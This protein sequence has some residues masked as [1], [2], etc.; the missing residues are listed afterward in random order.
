MFKHLMIGGILATAICGCSSVQQ[1]T[2]T[3]PP[4][5]PTPVQIRN[6]AASL[7][8]DLL[9]DE[10]NVNKVLIVKSASANNAALIKLIAATA[11]TDMRELE[12]LATNDPTLDLKAIDLPPGEVAARDATSKA[13][14]HDIL[15]TTGANFEFNLLYSQAEAQNYG[16]QLAGVA[17]KNSE[18]PDEAQTFDAI[19]KSM[20]GLD[21]QVLMALRALP[22]K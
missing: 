16:W 19:S 18:R 1:A 12:I 15:F 22:E 10:Q 20:E 7:L 13:K 8:Y 11:T 9:G 3:P 4:T 2:L 6:N 21:K 5:K 14:E 17:A